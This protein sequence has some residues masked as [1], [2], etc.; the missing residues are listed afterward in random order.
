MNRKSLLIEP[1]RLRLPV[2]EPGNIAKPVERQ[3][4][5]KPV[6]DTAAEFEGLLVVYLRRVQHTPAVVQETEIA[7]CRR[8]QPRLCGD[9]CQ[10]QRLMR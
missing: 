4:F 2:I 1:A 3:S 7:Q 10:P 5:S 9:F 8:H 6:T